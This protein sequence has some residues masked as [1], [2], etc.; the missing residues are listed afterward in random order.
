[1]AKVE[2]YALAL[3][4]CF[5]FMFWLLVGLLLMGGISFVFLKKKY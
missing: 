4:D 5:Y 2:A 3:T 1:M